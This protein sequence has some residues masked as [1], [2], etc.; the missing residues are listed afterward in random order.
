MFHKKSFLKEK[1]AQLI[2]TEAHFLF[3]CKLVG[4]FL[5]KIHIENTNLLISVSNLLF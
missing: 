5:S 2:K 3:V 4:P 1:K